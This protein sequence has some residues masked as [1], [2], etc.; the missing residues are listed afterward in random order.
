V[1]D[2]PGSSAAEQS[3]TPK[4]FVRQSSGLVR[5]RERDQCAVL[6][7]RRVRRRWTHAVPDLLFARGRERV[8]GWTVLR[9]W[10]G[11]DHRWAVL[12][13]ARDDL[14]LPDLGD[15]ALR[16]RLRVHEPDPAPVSG[17]VG[18]VDPG[19]C[20]CPHHR[21]RGSARAAQPADH[22][23]DHRHRR[24]RPFLHQRE[25][26]VHRRDGLDHRNPG[27][28]RIA[29]RAA[30]DWGDLRAADAHLPPGGDRP[31]RLWRRLLRAHVRVRS[32][33]HPPW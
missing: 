9:L 17:L 22:R 23:A 25:H 16:G 19:H 30:R 10:L 21:L 3:T 8:A 29:C 13:P 31:G 12:H 14:R 27:L 15:A 32:L 28:H 6:Q 24:R 33:G 11:G 7:R 5:K 2:Q 18:V 1:A 20:L 4:L 26:M